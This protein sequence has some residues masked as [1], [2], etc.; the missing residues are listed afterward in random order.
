MFGYIR[1]I[2]FTAITFFSCNAIKCATMN[3]QGF[4]IRSYII[5]SNSNE[6]SFYPYSIE[7]Q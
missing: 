1:A 7:M 6:P 4:R 3:N 2:V 5:N